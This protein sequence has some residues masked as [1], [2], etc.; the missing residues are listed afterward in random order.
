MPI[1]SQEQYDKAQSLVSSGKAKDPARL[2][3]SMQRWESFAM[4]QKSVPVE[5]VGPGTSFEQ[6]QN[7]AVITQAED[8]TAN[9][10]QGQA[11]RQGYAVDLSQP[12]VIQ[13]LASDP[14]RDFIIEKV[15]AATRDDSLPN[16]SKLK[17]FNDPPDYVPPKA[18][19]SLT[20]P[21][22]MLPT[23]LQRHYFYEPSVA[24]FRQTMTD[25]SIG[26]HLKKEFNLVED[27]SRLPD[28]EIENSTTFK[29]FQDA[30]WKHALADAMKNGYA[31][32]RV[33]ETK[34]MGTLDKAQAT[35]LD[36]AMAGA[37]GML[38]GLT[39]SL[40]R[41]TETDEEKR[42]SVRNPGFS[43]GGEILGSLAPGSIP[44]K[45]AVGSAKL[46]GKAGL[47]S[48]G[49]PGA[50]KGV[51]AA[52]MTGAA[53]STIRDIAK[54]AGD[55]LDAGDTAEEAAHRLY[56]T[57]RGIPANAG[58]GATMGVALGVGGE[59]FG[60]LAKA[61]ARS[62]V[63]GQPRDMLLNA[64]SSGV[65]MGKFGEPV[66]P[67]DLESMAANA[68]AK[69][70]TAEGL[71]AEEVAPKLLTQRLREQEGAAARAADETS[72][73]REKLGGATVDTGPLADRMLKYA[74]EMPGLTPE[75]SRKRT[76]LQHY[77][78]RIREME[79][80]NAKGLDDIISEVDAQANQ[81]GK[82]PD[83]DWNGFS[84]ILREG[85]DEFHFDEPMSKDNYA[86]RD[87]RGD[88]KAATDYS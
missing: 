23:P 12:D 25:G 62:I 21:L 40:S 65:R 33:S 85:R 9:R 71:I 48:R 87:Q 73:A 17:V 83:S 1:T 31:I 18:R 19:F 39:A 22:A 35:V 86:I 15:R 84:K 8:E 24:E 34:G 76:A 44:A 80:V 41:P 47:A 7:R 38:S 10:L 57:M 11:K 53:D 70:A 3:R 27:V 81:A 66:L 29:A 74:D 63:G 32:S 68:A 26:R 55:A 5:G 64:Q 46:L 67:K 88:V 60:G 54:F 16:K 13:N 45:L 36:P 42:S 56:E 28:K 82:K 20:N 14:Q 6:A 2:Q 75:A 77:A 50:V 43:L 30:A 61:G 49:L 79:R 78:N 72:A 69:R 37:N 4:P 58:R 51:G 52:A 59:V